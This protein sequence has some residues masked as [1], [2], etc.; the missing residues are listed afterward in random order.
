MKKRKHLIG[1]EGGKRPLLVIDVGNTNVACGL[2][3]G[4][5]LAATWEVRTASCANI[6][7]ISRML[8]SKVGNRQKQTISGVCIVSVVPRLSP[9][10]RIACKR[11]LGVRPLFATPKTIGAML[12]RYP[13]SQVGPD[14]LV[15]ALAVYER[16]GRA[17]VVVD[18]GTAITFDVVNAHGEFEGGAIAPGPALM[19][20]ALHWMTARLPEV[21]P[22]R[23]RRAI[24]KSTREC[25]RAGVV[26][27][28]AG[29]IDRIVDRIAGEMKG[30]PVVVATG[31]GATLLARQ[32]RTLQHVDPHLLLQGLRLV[33]ER[34]ITPV[35]G[36]A[37]R[38]PGA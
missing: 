29:L 37:S 18:I 30:R 21:D 10:F 4:R 38:A 5:R 3:R 36:R 7:T 2:F 34:Y 11:C 33:W 23:P 9:L 25:I 16:F 26:I 17:C 19:S 28:A 6:H 27:G 8:S 15:N 35:S 12:R 31:G 1:L 20:G 14:R 24:G 22:A 32:C 13:V